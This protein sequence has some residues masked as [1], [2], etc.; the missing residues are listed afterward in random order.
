MLSYNNINCYNSSKFIS[1]I[2]TDAQCHIH[3]YQNNV[4]IVF[5]GTTSIKD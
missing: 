3:T 2:Q 1:N 4:Y 5:R